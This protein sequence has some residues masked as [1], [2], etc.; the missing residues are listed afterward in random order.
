MNSRFLRMD[1]GAVELGKYTVG[2]GSGAHAA[3]RKC[4][5]DKKILSVGGKPVALY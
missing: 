1:L 4:Q 2:E 3:S 5:S